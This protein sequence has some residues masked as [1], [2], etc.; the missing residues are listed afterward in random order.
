MHRN[1]L[2]IRADV[3]QVWPFLPRFDSAGKAHTSIKC[4]EMSLRSSMQMKRTALSNVSN[5][6]V[7]GCKRPHDAEG[8]GTSMFFSNP[9]AI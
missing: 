7:F 6:K 2:L 3:G 4:C 9:T 8:A 5:D 1:I